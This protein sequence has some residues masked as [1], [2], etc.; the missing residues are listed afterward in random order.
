MFCAV[1]RRWWPSEIESMVVSSSSLK[2]ATRH[3]IAPNLYF[4]YNPKCSQRSPIANKGFHDELKTQISIT[5]SHFKKQ[6][7]T[8][9]VKLWRERLH[10]KALYRLETGAKWMESIGGQSF[11]LSPLP[12]SSASAPE[13]T[14]TLVRSLTD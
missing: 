3:Q 1:I 6:R 4:T 5:S 9:C 14:L 11:P 7:T 13:R 2:S 10:L 8:I 12:S